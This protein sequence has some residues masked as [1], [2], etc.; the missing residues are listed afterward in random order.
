MIITNYFKVYNPRA[1]PSHHF[2]FFD[3]HDQEETDRAL[4]DARKLLLQHGGELSVYRPPPTRC[5]NAMGVT[6]IGKA[7]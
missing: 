6:V 7:R 1:L 2:V 3:D 5:A 4:H